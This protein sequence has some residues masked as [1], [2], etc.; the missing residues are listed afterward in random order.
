MKSNSCGTE[1]ARSCGCSSA[2]ASAASCRKS[3]ASRSSG[4]SG[5]PRGNSRSA[6]TRSRI[7][8]SVARMPRRPAELLQHVDPGAAVR[9]VHHQMHRAVRF[10]H[11]AQRGKSRVGVREMMQ[12]AGA[13]DLIEAGPQFVNALDRQLVDLEIAQAVRAAK[14]LGT[15]DAGRADVDGGHLRRGPAHG[16]PGRLRC[17]AAGDEDG[18]V[19]P[20]R[21]GRP[22]EMVVGST[23]RVDPARAAD[24]VR[25]SSTGRGYGYR[26]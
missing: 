8:A 6:A 18:K 24:T 17:S 21:S 12:N 9:R 4:S 15:A 5:C 1:Y 11:V 13:H 7:P 25:G 10:Q 19:V 3:G 14:L 23:P 16:V 22:E 2:S 26:S 20:I